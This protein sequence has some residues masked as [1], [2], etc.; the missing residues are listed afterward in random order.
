MMSNS[1]QGSGSIADSKP[2]SAT[3]KS[4]GIEI[5]I[6]FSPREGNNTTV[7]TFVVTQPLWSHYLCGGAFSLLLVSMVILSL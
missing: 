6:A 1:I 7:V 2:G 5:N 3:T 4:T